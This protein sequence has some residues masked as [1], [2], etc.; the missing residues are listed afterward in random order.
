MKKLLILV[1][2]L[3]LVSCEQAPCKPFQGPVFANGEIVKHTPS[4]EDVRIIS[5]WGYF[6]ECKG[7]HSSA[8]SKHTVK[9]TDESYVEVHY[10]EL[11]KQ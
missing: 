8:S 3:A 4:K 9:F 10:K 6:T 7:Y 11:A 1:S 2:L 5:Q